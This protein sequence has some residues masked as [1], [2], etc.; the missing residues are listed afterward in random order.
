MQDI[1]KYTPNAQKYIRYDWAACDAKDEEEFRRIIN[2]RNKFYKENFT[3][4][5][6]NSM[7]EDSK[8]YTPAYN[9]WKRIRA[10]Y[11]AEHQHKENEIVKI[12]D[13]KVSPKQLRKAM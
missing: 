7:L 3:L 5:D 1:S 12:E 6:Y 2:E 9:M 11:L 4:E 10:R 13:R 8:N